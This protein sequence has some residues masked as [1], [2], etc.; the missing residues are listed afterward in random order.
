ML[1]M[2]YDSETKQDAYTK[3]LTFGGKM[4][5]KICIRHFLLIK[6]KTLKGYSSST[7]LFVSFNSSVKASSLNGKQPLANA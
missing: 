2:T 1:I 5:L 4:N 6:L 3:Y 7:F